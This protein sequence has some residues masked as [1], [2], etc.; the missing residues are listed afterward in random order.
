MSVLYKPL[1]GTIADQKRAEC[2]RSRVADLNAAMDYIA[3]MT[4]VDIYEEEAEDEQEF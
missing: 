4:G 3:M 1:S 2:D